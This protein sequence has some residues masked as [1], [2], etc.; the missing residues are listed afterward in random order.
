MI[1][2][3]AVVQITHTYIC[4]CVCVCIYYIYIYGAITE[5]AGSILEIFICYCNHKK[6]IRAFNKDV[7]RCKPEVLGFDSV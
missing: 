7:L 5:K 6:R 4:V 3:T 2:E 1:S